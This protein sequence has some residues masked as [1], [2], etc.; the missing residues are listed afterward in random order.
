MVGFRSLAPQVGVISLLAS[1]VIGS[2]V[3]LERG[4]S[5]ECTP[6][7]QVVRYIVVEMPPQNVTQP[8]PT[9]GG[10]GPEQNITTT[11]GP[12]KAPDVDVSSPERIIPSSK[13]SLY[14]G[15]EGAQSSETLGAHTNSSTN[16]TTQTTAP[17]QP[18]TINMT[19]TMKHYVVALEYIQSIASVQCSDDLLK[20]TFSDTEAFETAVNNWSLEEELVM[21]TNHMGNCDSEFER[22]FFKVE[23]VT[24]D[25]RDL[26]ISCTASKQQ[27][28]S[29]AENLELTFSSLPA[30]TLTKRITL[31][32]RVSLSFGGALPEDT[33]LLDLEPY[34][35][36]TADEASFSSTVTFSGYLK[37]NFWRFK[38]TDLYFDIDTSF[39]ADLALSASISAAFNRSFTYS[40][41]ALQYYL[42][43]VPGI[44]S[45][46]PGVAFGIGVD[47]DA[48]AGVDVHTALGV[49]L[50]GGN[51]H[52]DIL[53]SK[54]NSVSGWK[55]VYTAN[56][57]V[58]EKVD[59]GA[60]ISASVTV[61]L[62]IKVL[63]GLID[64]SSGLTAVPR[65]NNKFS[66]ESTQVIDA[67]NGV[68]LP[69]SG[70]QECD[71]SIKS[72]FLFNLTGYVT[73]YWRTNLYGVE[74]PLVDKC[75]EFN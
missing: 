31:D 16:F 53:N 34:L 23:G 25:T 67:T 61:E 74:V 55:P 7:N 29:I 68:S 73:K 50:P 33:V 37:Y 75:Y 71:L 18:G 46:G 69:A 39:D 36:I 2:N 8:P 12:C 63:G 57:N 40:P 9:T 47:I 14:Y 24:S 1:T 10:S 64:L 59:V 32:P 4:E 43:N 70:N 66:L 20:V 22:G 17:T 21:V 42:V 58:S 11:L 27:L 41:D 19:L 65:L 35:N 26:S 54:K 48:S 72:D 30:A 15:S 44:V 45:L 51:V 5:C 6:E 38:L 52:V 13:V 49:S 56:A 3:L 28:E 62:A 60:D